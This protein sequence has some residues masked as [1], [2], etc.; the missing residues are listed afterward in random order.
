MF[1]RF[2]ILSKDGVSH[3]LMGVFRAAFQLR[4]KDRLTLG[5]AP[6]I[7]E[8]CQWFNLHLPV[9][10]Q[11]SLGRGRHGR[12]QGICWFKPTATE[13][14]GKI[15]EMVALLERQGVRTRKL[16]TQRPGYVTYEDAYQIVAV[17]FRD[18]GA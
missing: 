18:T 1:V 7:E 13:H 17:P 12:R 14:L 4:D 3:R 16:R 15:R 2:V 5:I 6:G 9:P 10:G 8:L 11:F